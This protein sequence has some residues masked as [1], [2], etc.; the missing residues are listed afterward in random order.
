MKI[1]FRVENDVLGQSPV[2]ERAEN[3]IHFVMQSW[4]FSSTRE[5]L[6]SL[7]I[8]FLFIGGQIYPFRTKPVTVVLDIDKQFVGLSKITSESFEYPVRS[9]SYYDI[10]LDKVRDQFFIDERIEKRCSFNRKLLIYNVSSILLG[11]RI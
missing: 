1:G 7:D 2:F 10:R 8:P 9:K 6:I 3:I 11:E 5:R 4:L